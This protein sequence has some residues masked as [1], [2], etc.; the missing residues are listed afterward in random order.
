MKAF[1]CFLPHWPLRRHYL[2]TPLIYSGG[3]STIDDQRRHHVLAIIGITVVLEL[4]VPRW[5]VLTFIKMRIDRF[6]VII[7]RGIYLRPVLWS[8]SHLHP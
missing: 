5:N 4:G 2:R 7:G 1:V 3:P 8:N 6:V